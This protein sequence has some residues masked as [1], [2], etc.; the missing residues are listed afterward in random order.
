MFQN[1]FTTPLNRVEL[2][3]GTG[4]FLGHTDYVEVYNNFKE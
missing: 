4:Q 3:N 1:R 2:H